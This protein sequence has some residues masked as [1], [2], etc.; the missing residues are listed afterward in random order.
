MA[1]SRNVLSSLGKSDRRLARCAVVTHYL[2]EE[3]KHIKVLQPPVS[4]LQE[5]PTGKPQ[6]IHILLESYQVDE[7]DDMA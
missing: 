5:G 2:L 3:E 1:Y 7:A 6:H 4:V